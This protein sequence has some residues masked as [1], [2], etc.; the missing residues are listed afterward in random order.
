MKTFEL[1]L[2]VWDS[3]LAASTLEFLRNVPL[4]RGSICDIVDNLGSQCRRRNTTW[5]TKLCSRLRL[6]R[7]TTSRGQLL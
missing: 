7:L 2:V 6:L 5:E 1:P 3:V 4:E